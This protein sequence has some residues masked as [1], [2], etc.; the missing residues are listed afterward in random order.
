MGVFEM[1]VLIVLIATIGEVLKQRVKT[2]G[3]MEDLEKRLEDLGVAKQLRRVDNLEERV[4]TL[5][6]IATDTSH[7]LEREIGEL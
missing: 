6:R 2:R 5:E 3:R 4:R 1:V 7:R